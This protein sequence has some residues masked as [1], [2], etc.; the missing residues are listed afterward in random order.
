MSKDKFEIHFVGGNFVFYG[1]MEKLFLEGLRKVPGMNLIHATSYR[2]M[3]APKLSSRIRDIKAD[4]ILVL[5]GELVDPLTIYSIP[6]H[7]VL[8]YQDDVLTKDQS[9]ME[10]NRL[11]WAFDKVYT[12]DKMAISVYEQLGAKNVSDLMLAASPE[13]HI[14]MD[15]PKDYDVGLVGSMFPRRLDLMDRVLPHYKRSFF[16]FD[17]DNF[18]KLTNR[19]KVN[20]NRGMGD[21]G[22]QQ[23]V[24]EVLSCGGF[25]LTNEIP[26]EQ[27]VFKDREHLVYYTDDNIL[28]LIEYYLTHEK[29]R[30]EIAEN[31]RAEVLTK[32]TY[33]HRA[34]RLVEDVREMIWG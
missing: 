5:K 14:P 8:W 23:R 2:L 25:L 32:H 21:T 3:N 13:Y 28:D 15:L 33:R 4:V 19:I 6:R 12:F 11:A 27:K 17:I 1:G 31:G 20:I 26:E 18:V 24:F 16:G 9:K 7:A 29:E 22:I 34:E 30:K 10:V